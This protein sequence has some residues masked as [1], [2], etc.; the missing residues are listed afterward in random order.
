MFPIIFRIPVPPGM[1]RWKAIL[2]FYSLLVVG[3]I[4]LIAIMSV[5]T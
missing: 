4:V 3:I 2:I 5:F 1:P